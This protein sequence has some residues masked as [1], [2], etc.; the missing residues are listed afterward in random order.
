MKNKL[1]FRPVIKYLL[2][3][4]VI[5]FICNLSCLNASTQKG[6]PTR[7]IFIRHGEKEDKGDNLSCQGLNRALQLPKVLVGKYGVPNHI[8]VPSVSSKK[9]TGHA[10]MFQTASPLAIKYGLSINSK[11]DVDDYK[12]FAQSLESQSGTV[13]VVWEHKSMDNILK[14][15]DVKTH[16]EK[17]DDND[18]DSI[19]VVTFKNGKGHL[20]MD[21]EGLSPQANC[22]F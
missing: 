6:G 21:K 7:I 20:S 17:W 2:S 16:G 10:R 11:F 8:Y 12:D 9:S 22:Q 4:S 14:A 5:I 15:L 18:Y 3:L 1:Y 13:L 19:W